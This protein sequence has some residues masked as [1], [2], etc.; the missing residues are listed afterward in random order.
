MEESLDVRM[1]QSVAPATPSTTYNNKVP[2]KGEIIFNDEL[3]NFKVG[4]GSTSYGNLNDFL[5]DTK[6]TAGATNNQSNKLFIVG[7]ES[8]T[9]NP[10][11]YTN[12]SV[13]IQ[14]NEL[15]SNSQKVA[16]NDDLTTYKLTLNG[17][18]NGDSN[19]GEDLGTLYA[20]ATVGT[21]N[22]ILV[23]GGR[24]NDN[25]NPPSWQPIITTPGSGTKSAIKV[26]N[27][28]YT[29]GM[30]ASHLVAPEA[31]ITDVE[32]ET[33]INEVF[34]YKGDNVTLQKV[35]NDDRQGLKINAANNSVYQQGSSDN[36]EYSVLLKHDSNVSNETNSV[37]Y[38]NSGD[39]GNN[40]VTVNTSNGTLTAKKFVVRGGTTSGFL[41]ADGSVDSN[42][43]FHTLSSS[44]SGNAV[45]NITSSGNTIQF[46]L[47]DI[48][49]D[50]PIA[51][52]DNPDKSGK[53]IVSANANPTILYKNTGSVVGVPV[54][55][56]SNGNPVTYID[57]NPYTEQAQ[58]VHSIQGIIQ[59]FS[60]HYINIYDIITILA[61]D[62]IA[63]R[64]FKSVLGIR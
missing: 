26:G 24:I 44:G 48:S 50:I 27:K 35:V 57:T 3:N 25:D 30:G 31:T 21:V 10:Q 15:Y 13:Y 32:N 54:F 52:A 55:Y 56:S 34:F 64:L 8:Q 22:Q 29:I 39:N 20:P 16:L 6:N 62:Q 61:H 40:K 63:L 28:K 42:T 4:D 1:V 53:L 51:S 58:D 9:I 47:G 17:T 38:C 2:K 41:K 5:V 7:T 23:S 33:T 12:Q 14:D 36:E 19:N 11:S 43:Y 60:G 37:R 46:T 18:I 45:T 49:A 59:S